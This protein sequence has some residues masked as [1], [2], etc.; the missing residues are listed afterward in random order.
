MWRRRELEAA[1]LEARRVGRS[2]D[3]RQGRVPGDG[4]A[5]SALAAQ[6]DP[7]LGQAADERQA[8]A[9]EARARLDAIQRNAEA[10][11][12]LIDDL[13]DVS[14]IVS[15]K[16]RLSPRPLELADL[17]EEAI[18]T[19][20]SSARAKEIELHLALDRAAGTVYADPQRVRQ[21]VWNLVANAI[22]FTPKGGHVQVVLERVDSRVRL[23]V[24]DDGEGIAEAEVPFLFE[25]FWRSEDVAAREKTGLGLGLAITRSLVELHGGTIRASSPGPG[26]GSTFTVEFP[27]AL[28]AAVSTC[29]PSRRR[30][31]ARPPPTRCSASRSSSSTTTRTRARC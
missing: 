31:A 27:L 5:R 3:A 19:C 29:A 26:R 18:D 8:R 17:V 20:R 25:R 2:G 9:G 14:R 1:L 11:A 6:R 4:L 12:Q 10:Q 15:G 13:L 28:V 24:S 16:L 30:R 23:A 21:I 22:K 7:R